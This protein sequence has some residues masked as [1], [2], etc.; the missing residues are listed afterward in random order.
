MG[1]AKLICLVTNLKQ[2]PEREMTKAK[3]SSDYLQCKGQ[4]PFICQ[5]F[6]RKPMR[7]EGDVSIFFCA[8][9]VDICYFHSRTRNIVFKEKTSLFA[10]FSFI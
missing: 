6:Y 7:R 4:V 8:I 3:G 5:V 9:P 2:V 10:L 1:Y